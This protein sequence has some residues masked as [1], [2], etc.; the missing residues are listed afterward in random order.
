MQHILVLIVL[1]GASLAHAE[2]KKPVD[3]ELRVHWQS[4]KF[5]HSLRFHEGSLEDRRRFSIFKDNY[6]KMLELNYENEV[7]GT[8]F[9]TEINE[10]S[11]MS[12]DEFVKTRL[13]MELD[14]DDYW[15][16]LN[17][18]NNMTFQYP[19][20]DALGGNDGLPDSV[21]WISQ[22]AVSPVKN[23]YACGSCWSFSAVN[24]NS[25]L[26]KLNIFK[27]KI[28]TFKQRMVQLY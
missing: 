12:H 1:L 25:S 6:I 22:N 26:N 20:L 19:E 16:T 4:F 10:L 9:T 23:Q 17:A 15:F 11:Y 21:N 24:I 3:S 13:G 8:G 14:V 7:N 18:T 2:L 27:C 28:L 5:K